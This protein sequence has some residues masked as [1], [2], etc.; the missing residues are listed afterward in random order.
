MCCFSIG[1]DIYIESQEKMGKKYYIT[2]SQMKRIVTHVKDGDNSEI[3]EEGWKEVALGAA[4]L[5]GAS[6]G[7]NKAMA[8]QANDAINQ[9]EI[10][11]N[12]KTTLEDSNGV[13][14]LAKFIKWEPGKLVNYMEH[15]RDQIKID[16]DAAAKNTK[17][18][19]T[20]DIKD[21]R[22]QRVQISNK[23]KQGYAVSDIIVHSDTILQPKTVVYMTDVIKVD[24]SSEAMFVT[25]KFQL[26]PE[27]M[28]EINNQ[29]MVINA[30]EGR[31][32]GVNIESSTD[33]EPIKMGN[34]T[35]A[36]K[37]AESVSSFLS[38]IGVQAKTNINTLPNQPSGGPS[39]YKGGMSS[40]ERSLA[41][42]Q[43][44]EYRYVTVEFI[45]EYVVPTTPEL[46]TI[47]KVRKW[48]EVQM[49]NTSAYKKGKPVNLKGGG[50]FET[51][52]K[53]F[54]C[55]KVKGNKGTSS[56]SFGQG[57]GAQG[58]TTPMGGM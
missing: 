19:L 17:L 20:L 5:L 18:K 44:S 21:V 54:K 9:T 39:V 29:L 45:V 1:N 34:E 48:I 31:V 28:N 46:D 2:E 15:N 52:T 40:E 6:F 8:Q 10:L 3:L 42:E 26:K 55:K 25:G 57:K 53:N 35:L 16:F 11:Q 13:E 14:K 22:Q 56:C 32:M 36:Q 12:I 4:M 27:V 50:H 24:Y 41:R 23:L 58:I 38:S 43:T 49:V 37:R 7:G 33:K 30:G 47:V 51:T